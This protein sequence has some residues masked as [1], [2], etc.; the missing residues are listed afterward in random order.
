MTKAIRRVK[1]SCRVIF[2]YKSVNH[3]YRLNSNKPILPKVKIII[4]QFLNS[5]A[6]MTIVGRLKIIR[7]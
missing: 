5:A 7:K 6:G 4:N 2:L 1:G 3:K